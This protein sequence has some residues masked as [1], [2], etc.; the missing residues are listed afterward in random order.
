MKNQSTDSTGGSVVSQ[1]LAGKNGP[2]LGFKTVS[3][4]P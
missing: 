4:K 1:V 2:E 3:F